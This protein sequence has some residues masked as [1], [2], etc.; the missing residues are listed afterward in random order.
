MLLLRQT[1]L[2]QLKIGEQGRT[3]TYVFRAL[4]QAGASNC[5]FVGHMLNVYLQHPNYTCK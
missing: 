2:H 1:R 5:P 3:R 4:L